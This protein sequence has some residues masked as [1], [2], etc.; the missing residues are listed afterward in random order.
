MPRHPYAIAALTIA[1][2]VV[3]AGC[4]AGSPGAT[5]RGRREPQ[6]GSV[7]DRLRFDDERHAAVLDRA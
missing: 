3:L 6:P 1:C 2:A 5:E 7:R 4:A